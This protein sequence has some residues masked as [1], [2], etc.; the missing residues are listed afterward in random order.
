MDERRRFQIA[1]GGVASTVF[2]AGLFVWSAPPLEY[3]AVGGPQ[4]FAPVVEDAPG[5]PTLL[6]EGGAT[7]PNEAPR[8]RRRRP[9]R[10]VPQD[11]ASAAHVAPSPTSPPASETMAGGIL[12]IPTR[13]PRIVLSSAPAARGA[14]VAAS[15]GTPESAEHDARDRGPLTGAFATAG[16]EV[17]RG[18]RV[19]GRAIKGIF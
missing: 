17:G 7:E 9:A 6:P 4:P 8:S 15:P 14:R 3:P 18:F 11:G 2:I 1:L 5:R 13:G 10:P 12:P 19:A 16:K